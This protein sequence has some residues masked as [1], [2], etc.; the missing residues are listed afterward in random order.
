MPQNIADYMPQTMKLYK[1]NLKNDKGLLSIKSA[2]AAPDTLGH[3]INLSFDG[4]V[5]H[6]DSFK[7]WASKECSVVTYDMGRLVDIN[8]I[9]VAF[10]VS[11][12]RGNYYDLLVSEDGVNWITLKNGAKS[13]QTSADG[14]LNDYQTLYSNDSNEVLR[15]QYVQIKLRGNDTNNGMIDDVTDY[16]SIQEISIYG[17]EAPTSVIQ[18]EI[19]TDATDTSYTL[20]SDATVTI[21]STGDYNKFECVKMDEIIV[22]EA[23]YTVTEGSTIVTF[24][25][26]YL[27]TLS[28]GEHT[29][30]IHYTD[31]SCVDS[32]LTILADNSFSDDNDSSNDSDNSDDSS[33]DDSDSSINNND[34]NTSDTDSDSSIDNSDSNTGDADTDSN[35]ADNH[36][37]DS[38]KEASGAKVKEILGT[39]TGDSS[40]LSLWIAFMIVCVC[41]IAVMVV[42]KKK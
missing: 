42:V 40:N 6:N 16:C 19:V 23:N 26:E 35:A 11:R 37:D 2:S 14:P 39:N 30:T 29:V 22:D 41:G 20:G 25:A 9:D 15:A 36:E 3:D 24:K 5:S 8:T 12:D 34:S 7:T 17:T 13:E 18:P 28:R 38:N 31:G 32:E 21:K 27:E 4:F 1:L 10:N 33:T